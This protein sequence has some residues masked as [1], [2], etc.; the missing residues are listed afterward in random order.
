MKQILAFDVYGTLI[1]TQGVLLLLEKMMEKNAVLFS[2]TW[3]SKQLEYSFR[4]GLMKR[5]E[6]FSVCTKDALNYTCERLKV[7]LTNEQKK[8]LLESYKTLPAFDDVEKGLSQLRQDYQLLAF[9]NGEKSSVEGLLNNANIKS[10]F[11][12]IV[13]ADEIQTFKPDPNIYQH[14]LNRTSSK[15]N[16]TWLISS[17]PFDVIGAKS[18]GMNAAW[19]KRSSSAVYDP[20]G[21][22]PDIVITRL[23]NLKEQLNE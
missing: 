21:I 2:E 6:G 3:R 20:W 11:N 14:L 5:Y 13:S 22:E 12:D 17:N 23:D 16:Q 18:F 9:S 7:A 4:R 19:L 15:A 8:Q 10:Y 1:N